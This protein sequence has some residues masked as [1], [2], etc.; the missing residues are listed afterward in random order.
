MTVTVSRLTP[1][2]GTWSPHAK[3]AMMRCGPG[4]SESSAR[5]VAPVPHVD[6]R[7]RPSQRHGVALRG[8]G[9]D[10]QV[11]MPLPRLA[12][13]RRDHDVHA[14]GAERHG[15]WKGDG[16]AFGRREDLDGRG[17][18]GCSGLGGGGRGI[19]RG[20]LTGTARGGGR[21][22]ER[23]EETE[24]AGGTRGG[25]HGRT[26]GEGR[27][28]RRGQPPATANGG[29]DD[30]VERCGESPPRRLTPALAPSCPPE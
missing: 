27:L 25:H 6:H 8:I 20:T 23:R 10:D 29:Q 17:L 7:R 13:S 12:L 26:H 4:G 5:S 22:D 11:V 3:T 16:V 9:V 21:G 30:V 28:R 24:A 15:E 1:A 2:I 19:T 18:G 14:G